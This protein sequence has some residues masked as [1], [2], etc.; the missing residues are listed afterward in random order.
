MTRRAKPA[1]GAEGRS[2]F[3]AILGNTAMLLG[4]RSVTA[5]LSLVYIALAARGLGVEG[6][7]LLTLVHAYAQTL[8]DFAE[9][10]SWQATL[11]YGVKPLR[12]GRTADLHRVIRFSLL[13]DAIG[14]VGGTAIALLGALL[15]SGA[16]GLPPGLTL[17]TMLYATSILFMS[18]TTPLGVLRLMDRFDLVA[19]QTTISSIA[20]LA[21][22]VAVFLSGGGLAAYLAVWWIST[23]A[24]FLFMLVSASLVMRRH[25]GATAFSW[26][27][28]GPFTQGMPGAWAFVWNINLSSSLGLVT[29]KVALLCVGF[30]FG[31]REA[32]LFRIAKQVAD[33]AIRPAKLIVPALYPELARL[34][35]E[36]DMP[37]LRR[38]CLQ[39]AGSAGLVAT[40]ALIVLS[41]FGKPLI[42][43]VV[44]PDFTGAAGIMLW[45]FGAAVL[46]VW[47]LPL[48]PLLISTG[49]ASSALKVRAV[50]AAIYLAILFPMMDLVGLVGAGMAA[51]AAAVLLFAL[52]LGAVLRGR[53]A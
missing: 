43:F 19:F 47:G 32:A 38:L 29:G 10:N 42:A 4:G 5:V 37:R 15:F 17:T 51:L 6:F 18:S 16:L 41:L 35:A 9:F 46:A 25:A 30:F 7:G 2:P 23:F 34:W 52:Q 49:R 12:D 13:L 53:T 28:L 11:H 33:A 31:A 39:I 3:R 45:L 50:V 21:G 22:T 27:G 40:T 1:L 48:E 20:R 24:A 26:R 44:G 8:G 14:A 36:R